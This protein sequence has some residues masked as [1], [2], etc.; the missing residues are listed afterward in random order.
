MNVCETRMHSSKQALPGRVLI[1]AALALVLTGSRAGGES[2]PVVIRHLKVYYE[3]GRFGGWPANYGAWIWGDEI[4]VG[5]SRGYYK[6]LGSDRHHIDRERPEEHWLARSL[7]GG[8]SWSYEYPALG[9]HLVARGEALH[10]IEDPALTLPPITGSPGGFDF[11]HPDFCLVARMTD[12]DGGASYFEVSSDRGH[13]WRGPYLIP[14]VS[15]GGLAARTDYIIDGP[16]T[17]TLFLTAGKSDGKEGRLVC[18]RTTDGGATWGLRS[19]IGEEPEVGFEIMP[20]SVRLSPEEI[21]V[22]ARRRAGAKR[23]M[24]AYRS[25]DD[26]RTWTREADPVADLG[27][28]NPPAL[29]RLS[30][31]RLC[32]TYGVRKSPFRIE[33]RM[34]GDGGRTW[35]EPTVLRDDGNDRDI[36]YCRSV[37]RLDGMVVTFYY[38]NE[39]ATGPERYIGATIWDPSR[40]R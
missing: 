12:I 17:C 24:I 34:S 3:P 11:S 18:L 32:L 28:G 8:E 13:T 39:R 31:G 20:A 1:L 15:D 38:I 30:D 29:I 5:F 27:E 25:T 7:D 4:L 21:Y 36:G 23:W 10:G 16:R 37:Q 33:T 6:D 19:W 9:G 2:A 14:A 22:T 40:V 35:G 26:G